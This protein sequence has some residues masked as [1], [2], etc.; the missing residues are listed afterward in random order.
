MNITLNGFFTDKGSVSVKVRNL[1]KLDM[2][3]AIK[4][5]LA[6][7]FE[8]VLVGNDG[9]YYIP[10]GEVDGQNIYARLELTISIKTPK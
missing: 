1:V 4:K 9:A 2:S 6:S 7:G 3:N 10:L 5:V 8:N